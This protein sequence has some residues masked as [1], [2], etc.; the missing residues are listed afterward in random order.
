MSGCTRGG[1]L[2]GGRACGRLT[3]IPAPGA[4]AVPGRRTPVPTISA[5]GRN[6]DEYLR[7][8]YALVTQVDANVGRILNALER[9]GAAGNTLVI[10]TADHG[11]MQGSHGLLNKCLPHEMSSGVP[12]I[13]R[14]PG[15]RGGQV[16]TTAVS[17]VDFVPTMREYAGLACRPEL[18]G[19][20]LLP[21]L[22][23]PE[24]PWQHPVFSEMPEWRMV[25]HGQWKLV[26]NATL[27]PTMLF[28]LRGR[29][30]R[31]AESAGDR[32]DGRCHRA[33]AG[34]IR[35]WQALPR[36]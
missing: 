35:A 15:S 25:R 19:H 27:Q 16:C 30:P 4:R 20:S 33:A 8:Y 36:V 34:A 6:L 21:L 29:S 3:R 1:R 26:T 17:G 14:S 28:D 32:S 5:Y 11:D 10:F 24:V 9:S 23:E 13:V 7:L 12:L 2:A 31:D 18:P 22:G